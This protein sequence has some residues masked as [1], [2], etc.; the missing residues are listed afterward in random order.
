LPVDDAVTRKPHL[1]IVGSRCG[2]FAD[3][4]ALDPRCSAP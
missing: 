4:S 2:R 1:V 3:H